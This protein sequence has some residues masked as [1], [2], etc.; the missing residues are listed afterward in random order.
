MEG[1]R[2]DR[3]RYRFVSFSRSL[4]IVCRLID[5]R[6]DHRDV[7]SRTAFTV[8]RTR[9]CNQT[10]REDRDARGVKKFMTDFFLLARGPLPR[11]AGGKIT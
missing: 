10:R 5:G 9:C 11:P 7:Q 3:D 8:F 2:I 1:S 4:L 6:R